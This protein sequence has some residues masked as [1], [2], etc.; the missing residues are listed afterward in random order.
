MKNSL[1]IAPFL[2]VL[3]AIDTEAQIAE[4]PLIDKGIPIDR[5]IGDTDP[6][7][8]R[9]N[10]PRPN[11]TIQPWLKPIRKPLFVGNIRENKIGEK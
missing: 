8:E 2:I 4:A 11:N 7:L 9:R 10:N 3:I 5:P 6:I 1:L